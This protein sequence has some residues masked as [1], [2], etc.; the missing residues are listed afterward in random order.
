MKRNPDAIIEINEDVTFQMDWSCL[1]KEQN[2]TFQDIQLLCQAQMKHLIPENLKCYTSHYGLQKYIC[3]TFQGKTHGLLIQINGI[4]FVEMDGAQLEDENLWKT[5]VPKG[6]TKIVIHE[7]WCTDTD[8]E[9]EEVLKEEFPT[10]PAYQLM[11]AVLF[12]FNVVILKQQRNQLTILPEKSNSSTRKKSSA[13]ASDASGANASGANGANAS[14]A[15]D[16][17]ESEETSRRCF[18]CGC[19]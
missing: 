12:A 3:A 4:W 8:I 2:I 14:G 16:N 9:F 17:E 10:Q 13:N 6:R 19:S 18:F 11:L 7:L 1:R 5:C 15:N